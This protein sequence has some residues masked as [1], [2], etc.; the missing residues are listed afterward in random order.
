MMEAVKKGIREGIDWRGYGWVGKKGHC[1]AQSGFVLFLL[2]SL[3]FDF[4]FFLVF[5]PT[6][7][8]QWYGVLGRHEKGYPYDGIG[9]SKV[10]STY[11]CSCTCPRFFFQLVFLCLGYGA[12]KGTVDFI[13][14]A[15]ISIYQTCI[16]L[17]PGID[18]YISEFQC[19][20]R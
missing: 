17:S 8:I 5:S 4:D 7:L 9:E 6:I 1:W 14:L 19:R 2:I 3:S 18:I 11:Y 13:F 20:I 16:H 10:G 15:V 12:M